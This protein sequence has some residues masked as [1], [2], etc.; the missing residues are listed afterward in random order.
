MENPGLGSAF[1][2]VELFEKRRG[3]KPG[4]AIRELSCISLGDEGFCYAVW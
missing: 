3:N 1:C 4:A 2:V